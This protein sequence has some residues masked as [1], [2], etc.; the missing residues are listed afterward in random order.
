[1]RV[2]MLGLAWPCSSRGR[3]AGRM[4]YAH[5]FKPDRL[6]RTAFCPGAA[7]GTI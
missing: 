1:M 6:I 4:L 2:V 5:G 3:R 7:T